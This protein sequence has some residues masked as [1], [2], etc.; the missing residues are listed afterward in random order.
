MND[1]PLLLV[2]GGEERVKVAFT[3]GQNFVNLTNQVQIFDE[4]EG[5]FIT[6]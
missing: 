3:E 1:R 6:R 5:D 4:D 2:N